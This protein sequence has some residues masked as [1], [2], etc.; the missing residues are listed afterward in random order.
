MYIKKKI[1]ESGT[2]LSLD[3]RI[4]EGSICP[5]TEKNGLKARIMFPTV[6]GRKKHTNGSICIKTQKKMVDASSL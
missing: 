2:L 1:Y 6:I 4:L 3:K 5:M